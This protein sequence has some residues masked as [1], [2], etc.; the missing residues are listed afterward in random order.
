MQASVS[1]AHLR[2][3]LSTMASLVG[4][5]SGDAAWIFGAGELTLQWAGG[6]ST[7]KGAGVGAGTVRVRG[8]DMVGLAATLDGSPGSN[9]N[10]EI[11]A[12][13]GRLFIGAFSVEGVILKEPDGTVPQLLPVDPSLRDML[14]LG[15]L[16]DPERIASAGLTA[17]AQ[18]ASRERAIL[19]QK[20]QAILAPIGVTVENLNACVDAC[21]SRE[22]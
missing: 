14:R 6:S 19:V 21:L 5:A 3:T 11:R 18:A 9:A 20:A 8:G 7:F 13:G 4:R 1:V 22:P 15:V 12:A 17:A 16:H 2:S 10:A